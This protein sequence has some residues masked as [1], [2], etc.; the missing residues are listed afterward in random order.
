MT[1]H[2]ITTD[3]APTR[4]RGFSAYLTVFLRV[5]VSIASPGVLIPAVTAALCFG[6]TEICWEEVPARGRV[7]R[8]RWGRS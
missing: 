5:G 2:V 1:C 3:T 4:Y 7:E 6:V 8:C